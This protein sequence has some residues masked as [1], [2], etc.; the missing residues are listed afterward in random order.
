[1]VSSNYVLLSLQISS[2]EHPSFRARARSMLS[3]DTKTFRKHSDDVA[4]SRY[5]ILLLFS[6]SYEFISVYRQ[7]IDM[8]IAFKLFFSVLAVIF[9]SSHMLLPFIYRGSHFPVNTLVH[10][11]ELLTREAN[12]CLNELL[13]AIF[14]C[15]LIIRARFLQKTQVHTSAA[16]SMKYFCWWNSI[17]LI[18]LQRWIFAFS[19]RCLSY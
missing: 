11:L 13:N 1:M 17:K 14:W 10:S 2:P 4:T 16:I 3:G 9:G 12:V 5:L 7:N 19:I 8:Y 18:V 6:F 15:S